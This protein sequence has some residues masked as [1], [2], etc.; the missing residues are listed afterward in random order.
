MTHVTT[1]RMTASGTSLTT[2]HPIGVPVS[3]GSVSSAYVAATIRVVPKASA[4]RSG[5]KAMS[6]TA[7]TRRVRPSG[8]AMRA[9]PGDRLVARDVTDERELEGRGGQ[10]ATDDPGEDRRRPPR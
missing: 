4:T 8:T 5:A 7:R 1:M 6:R 3:L 10:P 2:R 9:F